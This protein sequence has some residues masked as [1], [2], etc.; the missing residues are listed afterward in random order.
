MCQ[1]SSFAAQEKPAPEE[2]PTAQVSS[3]P[4]VTVKPEVMKKMFV[5]GVNPA[6]PSIERSQGISGTV[7]L[8][9]LIGVDGSVKKTEYVSGS[10]VLVQL[11]IAA[12]SQW[13]YKPPT[14]HGKPVEVDTTVEVVFSLTG[15]TSAVRGNRPLLRL[16]LV[17]V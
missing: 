8:H 7:K 12:V 13:K 3:V 9:I 1:F 2:K 11:T 10:A 15:P 6:Y 16:L 14:V 4:R 17:G 5:H